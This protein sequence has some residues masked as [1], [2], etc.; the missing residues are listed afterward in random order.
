MVMVSSWPHG[1]WVL[2]ELLVTSNITS[3]FEGFSE[4]NISNLRAKLSG[5]RD[6]VGFHCHTILNPQHLEINQKLL[7]LGF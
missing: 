5:K 2:V 3:D 7:Y 4:S 6:I 1:Y